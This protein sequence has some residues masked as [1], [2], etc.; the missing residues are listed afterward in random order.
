MRLLYSSTTPQ[1]KNNKAMK[2]YK[3]PTTRG[4][5]IQH[6][7]MLCTSPEKNYEVIGTG[8]PNTPAGAPVFHGRIEWDDWDDWD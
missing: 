1:T 3:K 5:K 2:N 4:V 8:E 7:Q 6:S